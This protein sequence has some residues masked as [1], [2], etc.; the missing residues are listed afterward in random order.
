M[1][2]TNENPHLFREIPGS[3]DIVF[4]K[5]AIGVA[6]AA[7]LLYLGL[8][9]FFKAACSVPVPRG[10][11]GGSVWMDLTGAGARWF[12]L[13]QLGLSIS[14]HGRYYWRFLKRH[15]NHYHSIQNAGIALAAVSTIV[16][17]AYPWK[18]HF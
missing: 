16:T 4:K 17:Y 8:D 5:W 6:A 3:W 18:A 11:F 7:F 1:S 12:G 14:W 2:P 10:R 15:W 13:V 9:D